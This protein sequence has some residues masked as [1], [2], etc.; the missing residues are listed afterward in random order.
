M[1]WS[2]LLGLGVAFLMGFVTVAAAHFSEGT[3]PRTILVADAQG[4]GVLVYLRVPA[5]LFYAN[6][7]VDAQAQ[8]VPFEAEFLTVTRV[9]NALAFS[10]SQSEISRDPGGF[11]DR[12]NAAHLWRQNGRLVEARVLRW[13]VHQG[14][15]ETAFSSI[16]AA[17]EALTMPTSEV[18]AAFGSAYIDVE[19]VL[20]GA[21]Q[22]LDLQ[23]RS[24]MPVL[25]L[26]AGVS[27]DNHIRDL[28]DGNGVSITQT[29]QLQD[30][31]TIDGSLFRS[32]LTF[33][34]QGILHILLGAD[35]VLLVVCIALGA[36]AWRSLV[37]RVTAFTLGHAVTLVTA[38]FGYVPSAAWFIP[39]VET[40][41]AATVIYAAMAAWLERMDAPLILLAIGLLHG[42][43][44]SF[45]LSDIL[46]PASPSLTTSLAAFTVGIESGQLALLALVLLAMAGIRRFSLQGAASVRYLTLGLCAMTATYWTLSRGYSLL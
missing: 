10:L 24:A 30:W 34:W 1:R 11:A 37:A 25:P 35:H 13:N 44:F 22:G 33:T 43:G 45:V 38:F 16:A 3:K 23:M 4:G 8:Q 36:G 31:V 7:I 46:G 14:L 19:L 29:G 42:M 17:R 28:R 9:G 27:I 15:P 26:P 20:K 40:A 32:A 41:I 6:D 39:A 2:Q 12:L 18:D 5:P 21:R